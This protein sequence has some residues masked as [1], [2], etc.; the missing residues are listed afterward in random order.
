MRIALFLIAGQLLAQQDHRKWSDYGGGPD[1]SHYVA[2]SQITKSNV[3]DL[4]T[5]S[6]STL[7][8]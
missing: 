7:P 2:L 1:N 3:K 5:S 6:F 8:N 4:K